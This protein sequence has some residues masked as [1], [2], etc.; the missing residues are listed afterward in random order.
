[1]V[2]GV[3][4]K[5]GARVRSIDMMYKAVLQTVLFVE[6]EIWVITESMMKVTEE[7]HHQIDRRIMGKTGQHV[8]E[9][10]WGWTLTEK[11]LDTVVIWLMQ[12][13][14]RRRQATIEDYIET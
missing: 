6:S 5:A 7:F 9:E 3:L 2:L 1:M 11:S 8:G 12:E 4:V 13:Y 14:V 10:G